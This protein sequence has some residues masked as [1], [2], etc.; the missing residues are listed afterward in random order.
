MK[1]NTTLARPME[2]TLRSINQASVPRR[3]IS[4]HRAVT[5]SSAQENKAPSTAEVRLL[6]YQDFHRPF[7]KPLKSHFCK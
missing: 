6:Y 2:K 4:E 1:D 3:R 7:L 5:V